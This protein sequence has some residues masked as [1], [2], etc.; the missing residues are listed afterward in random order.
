MKIGEKRKSRGNENLRETKDGKNHE[1]K[2]A[3]NEHCPLNDLIDSR[4]AV[5]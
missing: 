3:L 4:V 1:I 5:G 2:K